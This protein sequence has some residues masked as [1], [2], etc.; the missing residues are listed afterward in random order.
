MIQ[1]D[2][3]L[4]KLLSWDRR[5]TSVQACKEAG[6][7]LYAKARFATRTLARYEASGMRLGCICP[8]P[9]THPHNRRGYQSRW[10]SLAQPLS[11]TCLA[12]H[13]AR[14]L[15]RSGYSRFILTLQSVNYL[16]ITHDIS[17]R[18]LKPRQ[19]GLYQ[20][21]P[22]KLFGFNMLLLFLYTIPLNC[23]SSRVHSHY[24][25]TLVDLAIAGKAVR[26][27]VQVQSSFA[28]HFGPQPLT[29]GCN[30]S[31]WTIPCP[32]NPPVFTS[33]LAPSPRRESST[34]HSDRWQIPRGVV[35]THC[36]LPASRVCASP[37]YA[38]RWRTC[39]RWDV[40]RPVL[41][42]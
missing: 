35:R 28:S 42:R 26:L 41:S 38:L 10:T 5:R 37:C 36:G 15:W 4:N 40:P 12:C 34:R 23:I 25:R 9:S 16:L 20:V 6:G 24:R 11:L 27:L 8:A 2:Y 31:Y 21:T 33:A 30:R 3:F 29:T 17:P 32:A 1:A 13:L 22:C 7:H 18:F 19:S 14:V 39:Q